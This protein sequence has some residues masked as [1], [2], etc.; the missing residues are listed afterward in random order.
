MIRPWGFPI[1]LLPDELF[2]SWLVRAALVQGCDPLVLTGSV[3][4]RWRV[5][6]GDPD[7]GIAADRLA[8]LARASGIAAT[9]FEA[10]TLRTIASAPA[11][12]FPD[13]K[14]VWPWV[15]AAGS[16]NRRRRGGLQYCPACLAEDKK[17]YYRLRWRL[18]WHTACLRHG[19]ILRDCCPHCGGTV[20]PHRLSA[21]DRH[22]A[23]CARC[24]G[25]L[26]KADEAQ[27]DGDALAFQSAA[28]EAVQ[29]REGIYGQERISCEE[30]FALSR[31]FVGLLRRAAM[32]KSD[33]LNEM[34]R[35]FDIDAGDLEAPA[36][37]LVLELLLTRERAALLGRV[38][39][40]LGAGPEAFGRAAKKA[41]ASVQT[42]CEM[43][44]KLP[45]CLEKAVAG[46]PDR[47]PER[48]RRK[49]AATGRP[50]SRRSVAR[51]WARMRR[52]MLA[53][54]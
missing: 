54:S 2:S 16:R 12:G 40:M 36:T 33:I 10:A 9:V 42:L 29:R 11:G 46:L 21:E 38:R 35:A 18:A 43:R 19:R 31:Y 13:G 49:R 24:K 34:L 22:L 30:W 15:L 8:A 3:W 39:R 26:R 17:P 53:D 25:D 4:P 5:W 45:H 51:M 14:A 41:G 28:D 48:L 6:T 37:G 52:A 20:E 1:P 32:G 44:Q 7:R 50:R 27:A 23:L 47:S